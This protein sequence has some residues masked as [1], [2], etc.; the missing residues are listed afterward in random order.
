MDEGGINILISP[1]IK[2]LFS[3]IIPP[4]QVKNVV[5]V[6]FWTYFWTFGL[7]CCEVQWYLS[8]QYPV[9]APPPHRP[10]TQ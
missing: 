1:G 2:N 6:Y 3:S 8:P 4:N 9:S 5:F 7:N 10:H